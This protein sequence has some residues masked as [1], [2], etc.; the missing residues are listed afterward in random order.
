MLLEQSKND[1]INIVQTAVEKKYCITMGCTTCISHEYRTM[2]KNIGDTT[3]ESIVK[4]T[5]ALSDIDPQELR[6]VP[7]WR[8]ALRIAYFDLPFIVRP[9]ILD[10]WIK[11]LDRSI[12]FTDYVT[13]YIIRYTSNKN[14]E[15][16]NWIKS[17]IKLAKNKEHESLTESLLWCISNKINDY[18]DF[19]D[20]CIEYATNSKKVRTALRKSCGYEFK[21]G[22]K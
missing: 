16:K 12:D 17:S 11:V 19:F 13:Y 6:F 1:F 5:K 3:E 4:L 15:W 2:L 21:M 9:E 8:D 7:E 18:P 20:Y 14:D 10:D 22:N